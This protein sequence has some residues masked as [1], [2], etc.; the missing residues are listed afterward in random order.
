MIRNSETN[1]HKHLSLSCLQRRTKPASNNWNEA[2]RYA[3]PAADG[4]CYLVMFPFA[5][6]K[7][8]LFLG[9]HGKGLDILT[10]LHEGVWRWMRCW[11]RLGT[12]HEIRKRTCTLNG[13]VDII[14][15]AR[16]VS[17]HFTV[18]NCLLVLRT[19]IHKHVNISTTRFP[20]QGLPGQQLNIRKNDTFSYN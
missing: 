17:C 3:S 6:M 11:M 15:T 1:I 2:P 16:K 8:F 14:I 9:L 10:T 20:M 5:D 19:W 4:V 13:M 12:W 7:I 18:R